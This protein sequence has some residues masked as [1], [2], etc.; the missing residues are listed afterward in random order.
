MIGLQRPWG[1]SL[2]DAAENESLVIV[3]LDGYQVILV[4]NV[5]SNNPTVSSIIRNWIGG[6]SFYFPSFAFVD[7][8]N[9]DNLYVSEYG[10]HRV[11]LFPSIQINN[12]PPRVVAGLNETNGIHLN[13]IN[14]A[15]AIAVDKQKIYILL[16]LVTIV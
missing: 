13:E 1:V 5:N 16:I 4:N 11:V 6:G 15:M 3:D 9:A 2:Y 14:G 12:P 7:I 8:E 10:N